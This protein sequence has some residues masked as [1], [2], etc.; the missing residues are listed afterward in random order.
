[1]VLALVDDLM[2]RS[3]IKSTAQAAGVPVTFAAS[4]DG[5]LA[6]MR[7]NPPALVVFDLNHMRADPLA[8]IAEMKKDPALASIPTVGYVSHV[9][10]GTID[11]AR[12]AGVDDV[13]ARSAFAAKLAEL[14]ANPPPRRG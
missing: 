14:L 10:V 9:D 13:V 7:S 1:M 2:F 5:A 6:S 8:T 12:A 4:K 11:A 3:K